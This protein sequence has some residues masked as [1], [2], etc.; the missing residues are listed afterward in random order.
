MINSA[1]IGEVKY[2]ALSYRCVDQ[3]Q[4]ANAAWVPIKPDDLEAESDATGHIKLV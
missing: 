1:I 4:A 2:R 3:A